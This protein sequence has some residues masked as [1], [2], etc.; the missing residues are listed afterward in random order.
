[1]RP[2]ARGIP[3]EV[4]GFGTQYKRNVEKSKRVQNLV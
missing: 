2:S 4:R 3:I 1:M